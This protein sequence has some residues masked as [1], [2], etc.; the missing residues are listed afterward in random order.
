LRRPIARAALTALLLLASQAPALAGAQLPAGADRVVV[1]PGLGAQLDAYLKRLEGYGFSGAVLAAKN[2]EVVL[3]N[4]YGMADRERGI[5]DTPG[6]IFD[7]GSITKQ[8]T[9]AAILKLEMEGRLQV[10][11]TITRYFPGVP[12]DKRD[13]TLHHLLT[14]TS[15]L[16]S[17]FGSDYEP[18][19]RDEIIR[20]ALAAPLLSKPGEKFEYSNAGYSLLA[21]V[22]E[23]VSERRYEDYLRANLF[24]P[25]GMLS[26]GYRIPAWD[27]KAIAQGYVNG[28]HRPATLDEPWASDGPWWN[29]RG[30]GGIHSDIWDMYRWH[31]AQ[32]GDS[33]L[34][35]EEKTKL[36]TPYVQ[37]GA[38]ANLSYAYGWSI[39]TTPR[40]THLV[41]HNG[42]NGI[43]EADF[44]RYVEENLVLFIAT[45]ADIPAIRTSSKLTRILL[46]MDQPLPPKVLKLPEASLARYAGA[47]SLP[48]GGSVR[49]A[50]DGSRLNLTAEGQS[51]LDNLTCAEGEAIKKGEAL[52]RLAEELS[53]SLAAGDYLPLQ[54]VLAG[55][56]P[57]ERIRGEGDEVWSEWRHRLGEFSRL[58]ALG[59]RAGHNGEFETAIRLD[60]QRGP[61][62]LIYT[63]DADTL[64]K[65]NPSSRA[66]Q[67]AL[68]AISPTE[69]TSFSFDPAQ[70][71]RASFL[72]GTG[73]TVSALELGAENCLVRA[74]RGH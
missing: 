24:A 29:L 28:E 31:L 43:F 68:F 20:R 14:H 10:T 19:P 3:A 13:I 45:N 34:S 54:K 8:F 71:Q 21:A 6:T 64:V 25:A 12:P 62:Y 40:G 27:R 48:H 35:S 41:T 17:D 30:N 47:Y 32:Q 60:F 36:T 72:L 1:L 18:V 53:R 70:E 2:G 39:V 33:I 7:I 16:R 26:T 44:R 52:N 67:V 49:L 56:T 51:T 5:K 57:L 37:E 74:A 46:G 55:D 11:D 69:F 65:V 38:D 23:R 15:G 42:G 9:A 63:W 4:G 59:T 58:E 50:K 22:I 66:P 61:A 73:G